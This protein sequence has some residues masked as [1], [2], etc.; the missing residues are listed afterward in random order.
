MLR[1]KLMPV[2]S[3]AP[4]LDVIRDALC[5]IE[6]GEGTVAEFERLA[7]LDWQDNQ[8]DISRRAT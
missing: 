7:T 8:P 5:A 2:P 1:E 6:R 4:P 3:S